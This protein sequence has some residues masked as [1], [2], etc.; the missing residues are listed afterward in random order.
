MIEAPGGLAALAADLAAGSPPTG[1]GIVAAGVVGLAAGLSESIARASLDS[2]DQAP[3]AAVQALTLRRRAEAAGRDDAQ[4]YAG[5]RTALGRRA[6]STGTGRDA[7]LRAVLVA[8]ADALLSIAAT[9]SDCAALA[10]EIAAHCQPELRA[11]AAGA[12]ALAAAAAGVAASLVEINLALAPGDARR[13]TAR[14][15]ARAAEF[16]RTAA[17]GHADIV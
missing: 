6:T 5:A 17:R 1:A 14:E 16:S 2:W 12:A 9:A 13:A 8:A 3:G 11:D 10:G 4:A 15:L 7:A